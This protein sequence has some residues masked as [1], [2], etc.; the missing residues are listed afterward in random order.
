MGCACLCVGHLNKF[1]VL[2]ERLATAAGAGPAEEGRVADDFL[3]LSLMSGN[4]Y[5]PGLM[6]YDFK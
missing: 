3:L 4:D 2:R 1:K 6:F 5:V